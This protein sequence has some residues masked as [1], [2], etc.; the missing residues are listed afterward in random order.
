MTRTSPARKDLPLGAR[1]LNIADA[2]HAMVSHRPYRRACR[3]E[4]AY[5]ELRRC[6]GTQFDPDL[7]EHFIEV[8]R[9]RDESRRKK[10]YLVSNSIQLE[11]GREVEELLFAVNTSSFGKISLLAGDLAVRAAKYGLPRIA[12]IA[13][14]IDKAAAQNRDQMEL[15]QLTSNLLQLCGTPN[16]VP[17]EEPVQQ[18]DMLVA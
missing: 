1:I 7:V 16:G 3:Y 12:K 14:E 13:S 15:V 11:I 18:Q 6:A 10:V 4:D 8:V 17:G 2:F 5:K 9:S